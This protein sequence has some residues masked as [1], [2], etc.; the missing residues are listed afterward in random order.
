MRPVACVR[1][2]LPDKFALPRQ[3]GRVEELKGLI[4]FEPPF[5]DRNAL[6]GL[7]G[8]SHIW[9]LWVFDRAQRDKWSPTVRPPRLGGNRRVGV[10]ATRSPFRPNPIALSCVRFDGFFESGSEGLC[11]RVSGVDMADGSPVLDI[12][13]YIPYADAKAGASGGW[14]EREKGHALRVRM[15]KE[16]P[17]GLSDDEKRAIVRLLEEDPRPAY[18]DDPGRVYGFRFAGYDVRFRVEGGEAILTDV[19]REDGPWRT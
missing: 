11:L 4:V 7:E 19:L 10:F 3:S 13:P 18:I 15:E 17:D 12:K 8:F 1:T 16:L 2:G 5:R 6:K 9:V 14:A